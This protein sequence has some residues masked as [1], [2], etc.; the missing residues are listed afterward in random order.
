M[1][2]LQIP[3]QHPAGLEVFDAALHRIYS[4]TDPET[5]PEEVLP[6]LLEITRSQCAGLCANALLSG[7]PLVAVAFAGH[8]ARVRWQRAPHRA[9]HDHPTARYTT[10]AAPAHAI[11]L[12]D[13]FAD[14]AALEATLHYQQN[15]RPLGLKYELTLL[16][17]TAL[18]QRLGISLAR[19]REDYSDAEVDLANRLMPHVKRAF[20]HAQTITQL[21]AAAEAKPAPPAAWRVT[22][23]TPRETEILRWIATG[24]TNREIA[25]LLE[26]TAAT[27]KTHLEHIYDKLGVRSRTAA[28]AA[29]R[30]LE[31]P[32]TA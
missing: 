15:L 21:R 22:E 14:R 12:T 31:P 4:A 17:D 29:L 26:V 6:V 9:F 7:D 18:S 16:M 27:V 2:T 13:H 28:A 20:H 3:T 23:L 11:R 10:T 30:T 5:F 1:P 32:G 24:R 25:E 19:I 8:P